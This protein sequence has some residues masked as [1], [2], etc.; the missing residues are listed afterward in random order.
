MRLVQS[1]M[2][3]IVKN[4]LTQKAN[5]LQGESKANDRGYSLF[6]ILEYESY[7]MTVLMVKNRDIDA[8]E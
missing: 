6:V 4:T 2:G 7:C 1:C 5:I 8:S 3:S